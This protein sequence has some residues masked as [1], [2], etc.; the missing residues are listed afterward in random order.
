MV[1]TLA[2]QHEDDDTMIPVS[3]ESN[4]FLYK[5]TEQIG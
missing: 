4:C 3:D 2:N 5:L 1:E